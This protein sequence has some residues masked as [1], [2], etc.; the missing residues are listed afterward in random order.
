MGHYSPPSHSC[1]P[2]LRVF[3][4]ELC[5][6]ILSVSKLQCQV[7]NAVGLQWDGK[8]HQC[9]AQWHADQLLVIGVAVSCGRGR[10][11]GLGAR[12]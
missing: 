5:R 2:A 1:F 12:D 8:W 3:A 11:C 10:H 6:E 7:K 9:S 4:R